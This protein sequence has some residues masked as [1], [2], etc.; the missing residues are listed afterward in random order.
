MEKESKREENSTED[1]SKEESKEARK[2]ITEKDV[3]QWF[4]QKFEGWGK[5][6]NCKDSKKSRVHWSGAGGGAYFV[7][8]IGA[9]VYYIQTSVS[10]WDGVVG[11]LKACVWPAFMVHGLLKFLG[12]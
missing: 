9:L 1:A 6:W 2:D 11:I 12:L 3:E 4:K 7:A 5:D 10:F 8:F